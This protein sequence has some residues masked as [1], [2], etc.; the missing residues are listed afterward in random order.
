MFPPG[1]AVGEAI[2]SHVQT[3][4]SLLKNF[5]LLLEMLQSPLT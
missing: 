3:S 1:N 5:F 4:T 2:P